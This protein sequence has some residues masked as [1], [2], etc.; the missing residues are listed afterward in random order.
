MKQVKRKAKTSKR[1][2]REWKGYMVC[3][4]AQHDGV[5]YDSKGEAKDTKG[6]FGVGLKVIQV[7]I[8]EVKSKQTKRG[9]R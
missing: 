1:K 2:L 5:I 3:D 8:I 6:S 4:H 7:K 9:E